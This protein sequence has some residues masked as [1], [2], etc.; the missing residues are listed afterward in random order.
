LGGVAVRY[1]ASPSQLLQSCDE[2]NVN[3]IP[4]GSKRTL[5]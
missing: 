1:M 3:P 5:G 4:Q 2:I